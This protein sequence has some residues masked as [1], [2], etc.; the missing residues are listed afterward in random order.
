MRTPGP[1]SGVH[2]HGMLLAATGVLV[3]SFDSLL[4]RLADT[5]AWNVVFW[6]GALIAASMGAV[7]L[8]RGGRGG[9]RLWG[10]GAALCAVLFGVDSVLFV[11]SVMHTKVANTV[12]ILSASPLFAAVFSWLILR[13]RV[14]PRTW[15]AIAAAIAGVVIVFAGSTGRGQLSGNGYALGAAVLAGANLNLLRRNAEFDRIPLVAASGLVTLAIALPFAHP[16]GLAGRSY[17]A[18]GA[19]GLLQMPLAMVLI[20]VCTRYLPAPELSLFLLLE[21]V[22]APVWIWLAVGERPPPLTFVGGALVLGAIAVHSRLALR[23]QR[24]AGG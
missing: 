7:A 16:L 21:T 11:L 2:T 10:G 5:G 12:V 4:V 18:L 13:E 6:R 17:A 20:A 1:A 14:R 3:L 8:L 22:L 23:E 9:L 24:R 15:A 19:M